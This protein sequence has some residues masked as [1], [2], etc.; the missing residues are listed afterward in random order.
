MPLTQDAVLALAPDPSS[1]KAA[2][3]LTAV[4]SWPVLGANDKAV[5]GECKG[6]GAKPYQVSVDL[7]GPAFRCTCP[8]RKFPCK[9]GLALLLVQIATPTAFSGPQEPSW[10]TDWLASRTEKAQ[11]KE[12]KTAARPSKPPDPES[13]AK[14]MAARWD[15]I[16][17]AALELKQWLGDRIDHGL[18]NLNPENLKLWHTMAARMVDAQAPGLGQRLKQ[19]SLQINKGEHWH[20]LVLEELGRLHLACEAVA[21]REQLPPGLQADLRAAVGWPYEKADV[22]A[23]GEKLRDEW[24][25]LGVLQEERADRLTERHVWLEGRQSKQRAWMLDHA[26]GGRGFEQAWLAGAEVDA[27]LAFFAGTTKLRAVLAEAHA[28]PTQAKHPTPSTLDEWQCI[29]TRV[30]ANPWAGIHPVLLHDAVPA[31]G[32]DAL[33]IVHEGRGYAAEL[34]ND[35]AWRL[36]AAT[37]GHPVTLMA[38]WDGRAL[39]PL[40]AWRTNNDMAAWQRALS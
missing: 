23:T 39:R 25:V 7:A 2:R 4:A 18:G 3:G 15:R 33:W 37:A 9:H 26:H 5:W 29:A 28:A 10:I 38:A 27:T 20:E 11:K 36:L 22:L 17:V 21:R 40:T 16:S 19:A 1:A 34:A 35:D 8:S 24:C 31:R 6:S 14:R 32:D 30:A 12:E 13:S